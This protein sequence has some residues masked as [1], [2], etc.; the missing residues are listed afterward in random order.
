M[1]ETS[2]FMQTNYLLERA[3][4]VESL[5]RKVIAN[6]IANATTTRTPEGA[7]TKDK[8]QYLLR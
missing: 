6:N 1:F 3:L 4:D 5:R 8:E 7:L 2:R